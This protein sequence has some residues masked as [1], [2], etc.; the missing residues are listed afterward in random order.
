MDNMIIKDMTPKNLN[1]K[2]QIKIELTME[3]QELMSYDYLNKIPCHRILLENHPL[4]KEI[5][6]E[7]GV[8]KIKNDNNSI[9][10]L[11]DMEVKSI[12]EDGKWIIYEEC[13]SFDEAI[14]LFIDD[15]EKALISGE[16]L[17]FHEDGTY[18]VV[19]QNDCW[20]NSTLDGNEP[21]GEYNYEIVEKKQ[22]NSF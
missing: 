10:T 9:I 15:I 14:S 19:I 18:I 12:K 8:L 16:N 6:E 4:K 5:F 17:D 22:R 1:C 3:N 7:D 21:D 13:G 2:C 11:S 20:I